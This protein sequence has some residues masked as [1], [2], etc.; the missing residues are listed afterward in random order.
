MTAK[1]RIVKEYRYACACGCDSIAI[2]SSRKKAEN[3]A[4]GGVIEHVWSVVE[5]ARDVVLADAYSLE[6]AKRVR[7]TLEKA[8]KP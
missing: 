6:D 1:F 4:H 3:S 7:N 2:A 8:G 5:T